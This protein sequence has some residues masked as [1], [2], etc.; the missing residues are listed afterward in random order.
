MDSVCVRPGAATSSI[1]PPI[2]QTH[3][4]P[5]PT[6]RALSECFYRPQLIDLKARVG[7]ELRLHEAW[8]RSC[9][10][11]GAS[12]W[13][14][15]VPSEFFKVSSQVYAVMLQYYMAVS[16]PFVDPL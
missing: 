10:D 5:W 7:F 3:L 14:R 16:L 4:D 15:A 13:I 12:L 11:F 2:P 9:E 1:C 6:Q 8:I